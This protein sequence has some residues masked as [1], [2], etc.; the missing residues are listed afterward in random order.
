MK[1]LLNPD[2][3]MEEVVEDE[4]LTPRLSRVLKIIKEYFYKIYVD[5]IF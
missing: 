4:R 1:D 2:L 5:V 3:A